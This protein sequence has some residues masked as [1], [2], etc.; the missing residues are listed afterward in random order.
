MILADYGQ[1]DG[2]VWDGIRTYKAY[3]PQ[4]GIPV[5]R[6]IHPRWTG[7]WQAAKRADADIYY[8]SCADMR[9]GQMALFA[10]KHARKVIFRIAHDNDCDPD[11]L[12]ISYWRD[13]K[14]YEYGLRRM[15]AVLAQGVR[16]QQAMKR[17]YGVDTTVATMFVDPPIS[18]RP[19]AAR[20]I[21][22]LWVNYFR[23]FKRPERLPE[24]A[25]R[26]PELEVHM[27][28]GADS[29]AEGLYRDVQRRAAE[30]SNLTFHGPV[31]Y[32]DVNEYYERSRVFVNTSDSEGFPNSYLQAWI[33]G[34][35]VIAFF[36]PDGIIAREGLG[37]AVSSLEEM[38]RAVRQLA[39]N[40]AEWRAASA[41]CK[42]YMQ[43][44]YGEDKILAP[45]LQ[46][47]QRLS[48]GAERP[49]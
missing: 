32:H 29:S 1:P 3:A 42:A 36:D 25:A 28:G 37:H 7:L 12:L 38:A 5:L 16:Q 14:L 48:A 46:T 41:R 33:R 49:A 4:A 19:F 6:F 45:Y 8:V 30:I 39:S 9:V 22:V 47:I 26:L 15:D 11:K 27:I 31:P 21:G 40:E 23:P 17:N 13:R 10:R 20:D 35:P 2:A 34:T 24:L 43:R 44:E 18:D